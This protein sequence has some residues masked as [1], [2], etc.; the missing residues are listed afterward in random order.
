[1]SIKLVLEQH[2]DLFMPPITVMLSIG[3]ISGG[4][5]YIAKPP[6]EE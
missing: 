2:K 1:M 4:L 3:V 6:L 5:E